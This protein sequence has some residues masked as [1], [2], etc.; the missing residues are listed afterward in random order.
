MSS[1][2]INFNRNKQQKEVSELLQQI[3]DNPPDRIAIV[4]YDENDDAEVYST[5]TPGKEEVMAIDTLFQTLL[6]LQFEV[7]INED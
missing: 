4:T 2:V 3:V 6:Q 5:F 7:N 1:N